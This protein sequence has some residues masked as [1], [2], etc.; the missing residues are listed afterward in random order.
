MILRDYQQG[1]I[2]DLFKWWNDRPGIGEAPILVQP[3]GAGKSLVCAGI[4]RALFDLWPEHH[5]RT[6][7]VVPSK[8]LAEQNGEKLAR[9]LPPHLR[10]GYYSASLGRKD[11]TADVIVATIGSVYRDA[12]LL[13]N[14]NCIIVD[15]CHLVNPKAKDA[16][17][18]RQLFADLARYCLFRIVGMT[19]TPFRGNG[20]WLTDGE[21]PLFTG[22]AHT[23]TVDQL[24]DAGYLAPLTLPTDPK[25]RIDTDGIKTSGGDYNLK[26]LGERS[27]GYL[28][29]IAA[30]A[31]RLAADRKKWIAFTATVD[32]AN[33]LA[34]LLNDAGI[35]TAVVHGA[36]KKAEREHLIEQFRAGRLRCLVTVLALSTGFDVP[37][38]DCIIWAR[39]T[40]SPV[41]YV[42]GAGRG[43]RIAPGKTDCLWLDFSDTTERLGP[44][45][46]IRGR[47]RRK[48]SADQGAPFAICDNCGE[49][50]SPA[51]APVCPACGAKMRDEKVD[52][53]REVSDAAVLSSQVVNDYI[54]HEITK[55]SYSIHKKTGKPDSLRVS[56]FSGKLTPIAS[57]WVCVGHDGFA[58]SKAVKW[59][60]RR[61][62][63]LTMP[64]TAAEALRLAVREDAL[65]TPAAIV[66]RG[67]GKRAEISGY[68]FPQGERRYAT[69]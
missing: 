2:D 19:A 12:H 29:A 8:E 52:E 14:I 13:G 59:W 30:D 4:A 50:V 64:K 42:Q 34:R 11:P 15:E 53:A 20:I 22:I 40:R 23:T 32:N 54:R 39:P 58:R 49:R 60:T 63:G 31:A 18:Y 55:V 3:T 37:D 21:D 27:V 1:A 7:V 46:M 67:S 38:I 44:V 68:D 56:Y 6:L 24:L 65:I 43:M 45:D 28:P 5:P 25:T 62:R 16:G 36:T 61:A 26:E 9:V 69:N 10:I 57:E 33:E 41:L 47:K 66:L 35:P 51:S 17:Q 48:S